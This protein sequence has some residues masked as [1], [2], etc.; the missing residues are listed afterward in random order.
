MNKIEQ[1]VNQLLE[2]RDAYYNSDTPSISD[3]EFD[4]LEDR[5]RELD[6]DNEYFKTVGISADDVVKIEH[7]R[8]MLSMQKAKTVPEILK[9]IRKIDPGFKY[10]YCIEPK[11]DGLSAACMYRNGKLEYVATRGDGLKGQDI[12]HVAEYITDIPAVISFSSGEVEVRGEL[13]LP[14]DTL[15][16]TG[17]RPLRNNCVGLINR[18]ENRE[19]LRHVRFASY[20]IT[21]DADIETE[22]EKVEVLKKNGF[23]SIEIFLPHTLEDFQK[24]FDLYLESKRKQW[25]YETDGLIITVDECRNF[26]DID[27]RW[28]VD[29]HHHYAIA[30]KPPV[31]SYETS[32]KGIFWQVSRQGNIIPV[33]NFEPVYIGGARIERATLNNYDNVLKLDL[34]EGDI[35]LI[36]RA[37]DV[38]PY[39]RENISSKSREPENSGN[40]FI[41]E[42]CPSCGG[43]LFENGVH[44]Q[45]RN[46]NCNEIKIQ[47]I[48][49]W[50]KESGMETVAEATVRTLFEKGKI[51]SISDLYRLEKKDFEGI[52]GFGEKKTVKILSEIESSR[53]TSALDVLSRLGIPLVQKKALKKLGI[54][55]IEQFMNFNDSSYVIGRNIIEWKNDR[56]NIDLL[57]SLLAFLRISDDSIT[58]S[59]GL[60]GMTGKGPKG[61]NELIAE[62]EN[63]GYEF[64]GTITKD[65]GILLCEDVN[66]GSAKLKKAEKIGVKIMSYDDFFK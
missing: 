38:I 19:D 66:S 43:T 3:T 34:H 25:L 45:C 49:Y 65:T 30:L 24:Y 20:Q 48:L 44:L 26:E 6:S 17:G 56:S 10:K 64:T 14:K 37:N 28:V 27:S 51:A 13:Y 31:E 4:E 42:K 8:P 1:I 16:D 59:K 54:N 2:A 9:W 35:L 29:H 46:E 32:L 47:K 12:S 23:N 39:I 62:I 52:E 57:D 11:I 50:V 63:L 55:S 18:K 15:Y 33:A 53:N 7:V 22:S 61:R 36:E 5:L 40:R 60:V 41:L 21:G 58:A